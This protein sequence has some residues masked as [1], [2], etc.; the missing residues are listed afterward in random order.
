MFLP[1][2]EAFV[3][4]S[5]RGQIQKLLDIPDR[6][7][8]STDFNPGSSPTLAPLLVMSLAVLRYRVTDPLLTINA[9]TKNPADMLYMHDRGIIKKGCIADILCLDLD[10]FEQ[11]PY[12]GTL[13]VV[14]R[15]IKG[16]RVYDYSNSPAAGS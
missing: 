4:S 7:V 5:H 2:A 10:N 3:F 15:V 14:Q 16:G 9:F 11:L 13:P 6:L 1:G 12:M 8:L